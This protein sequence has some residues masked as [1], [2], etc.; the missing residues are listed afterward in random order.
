MPEQIQ[1]LSCYVALGGDL[2]NV[3]VRG[4]ST[5]VTYPEML[6]LR[7]IHGGEDKVWDII[8]VGRKNVDLAEEIKRLNTVY[9]ADVVGGLFPQMAGMVNLPLEDKSFPTLE[10]FQAGEAARVA[11]Q[12]EARAKRDEA[13]HEPPGKSSAKKPD[14]SK[15]P[16][17]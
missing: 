11:A 12:A 15:L 3:A 1:L 6:V 13:P 10:E 8:E 9:G 17:E 7:A 5:P 14:P 2:K 4:Q 16:D